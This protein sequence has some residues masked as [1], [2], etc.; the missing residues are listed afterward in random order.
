[1]FVANA[2]D[3]GRL[4]KKLKESVLIPSVIGRKA[5]PSRFYV[6]AGKEERTQNSEHSQNGKVKRNDS[7]ESP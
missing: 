5:F 4:E 7:L 2:A 3:H 1:M 6:V